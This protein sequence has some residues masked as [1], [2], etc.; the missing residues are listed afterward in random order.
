LVVTLLGTAL[1][2]AMPSAAGPEAEKLA[3]AT[4]FHALDDHDKQAVLDSCEAGREAMV[5]IGLHNITSFIYGGQLHE[6]EDRDVQEM[7]KIVQS[8]SLIDVNIASRLALAGASAHGQGTISNLHHRK[9]T[10]RVVVVTNDAAFHLLAGSDEE[11]VSWGDAIAE[12][13]EAWRRK[14]RRHYN[15]KH[16]PAEKCRHLVDDLYQNPYVQTSLGFII[17]CCFASSIATNTLERHG[18]SDPQYDHYIQVLRYLE[19]GFAIFFVLELLFNLAGSIHISDSLKLFCY[20]CKVWLLNGWNVLDLAVAIASLAS[21]MTDQYMGSVMYLRAVRVLRTVKIVK[22]FQNL[23]RLVNALIASV[24]PVASSLVLLLLITAIYALFATQIFSSQSPTY[25]GDFSDSFFSLLQMAT[26]DSWASAITRS[27]VD[28]DGN[29]S[30]GAI[31]FFSSYMII[32]GTVLMNVVVAVLL[33][34]FLAA[35]KESEHLL[36]QDKI[37][38]REHHLSKDADRPCLEGLTSKLMRFRNYHDLMG[39]IDE[40]FDLMDT[41]RAGALNRD[42]VNQGLQRL[43]LEPHVYVS[44]DDWL[45]I[46]KQGA[47]CDRC[48]MLDR[49]AWHRVCWGQ[50]REHVLQLLSDTVSSL[51]LLCFDCLDI[52]CVYAQRPG[53]RARD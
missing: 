46:T 53:L 43:H 41:E 8:A 49:A 17:I 19:T 14:L 35:M 13:A 23:R 37:E 45:S 26:G 40:T 44:V 51:P 30:K 28:A 21:L 7:P 18:T 20:D 12:A 3:D 10:K 22:W 25:F 16:G 38:G 48:G 1:V 29:V 31:A 15:R 34:A 2:L 5:S 6:V 9:D 11:A 33:D 24:V 36:E 27:I 32:N 42:D 52:C 50:L 39:R 4:D 47:L